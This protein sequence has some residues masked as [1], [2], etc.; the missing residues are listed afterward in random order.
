M[1][2]YKISQDD[3]YDT[4]DSAIVCAESEELA[5]MI[6]PGECG[7]TNGRWNDCGNSW[8]PF[9]SIHKVKVK[10]IG[11]A[12]PSIKKGVVLASFNAA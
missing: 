4:D 10:L 6:H 12:S 7:H 8:V 2:L 11:K 1:N 5:R 9:I 3:D